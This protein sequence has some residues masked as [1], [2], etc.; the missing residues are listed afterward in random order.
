MSIILYIFFL[1]VSNLN[2]QEDYYILEENKMDEETKDNKNI[3][4]NLIGFRNYDYDNGCDNN[5]D[6]ISNRSWFLYRILLINY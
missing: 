3:Y 1:I 4:I 6:N 2:E 5:S